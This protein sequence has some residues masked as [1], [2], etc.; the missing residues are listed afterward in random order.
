V[1][2]TLVLALAALS[3]GTAAM[4]ET[5]SATLG[6]WTGK[7]DTNRGALCVKARGSGL[8][9][10]P[11]AGGL[12]HARRGRI[13]IYS[14]SPARARGRWSIRATKAGGRF[15]WRLAPRGGK[16]RGSF[17]EKPMGKMDRRWFGRRVGGC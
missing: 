17:A 14:V 15:E 16:F 2:Q 4:A 6:R 12:L 1:T 8:A 13:E 3:I 5:R 11:I 10:T 7:W 9:A